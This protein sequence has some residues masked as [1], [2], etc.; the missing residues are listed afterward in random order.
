MTYGRALPHHSARL[1]DEP[2][3]QTEEFSNARSEDDAVA[4]DSADAW[5]SLIAVPDRITSIATRPW[6]QVI[7]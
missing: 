7:Q 1:R 6:A 3:R 2:T 5:N 4:T